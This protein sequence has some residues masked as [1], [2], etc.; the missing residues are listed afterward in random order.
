V[1]NNLTDNSLSSS[2]FVSRAWFFRI[3]MAVCFVAALGIRLYD[4]TDLPLDF[5]P[6]RQLQS[7]IKAR[8][9]F[10]EQAAGVPEWQ[11]QTAVRQWKAMPTEEPEIVE[12]LAVWA[13]QLTGGEYIWLPR[14]FSILFWLAG[15]VGLLFLARSLVGVDGSVIATCFYLFLPYGVYASRAFM[16]DPLMLMF[17]IWGVWATNRWFNQPSWKNAILAGI[18]CGLAIL[19][20]LTA[21]FMIA[22]AAAGLLFGNRKLKQVLGDLQVWVFGALS[23]LPAVIYNLLGIYILG[24]ISQGSVAQRILLNLLIDPLSYLRWDNKIEEVLGISAL[25]LA[26]AGTFLLA[27]RASRSLVI[28]LWA[29]YVLF[30]VF[31]MYYFGTHNYY[32]LPLIP[33]VA[34]GIAP[35]GQLIIQH[36]RVTWPGWPSNAV[37][38]LLLV[39]AI[40]QNLWVERATLRRTDYRPE[41]AFWQGLGYKLRG[42][43]VL[44]LTQDY[45]GRLAY[46]GWFDAVYFPTLGDF[47]HQEITGHAVD[48]LKYFNE[49]SANKDFFLVTLLDELDAQPELKA[50]L[51]EKYPIYS[52]D[53]GYII[54]DLRNPK[55]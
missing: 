52:Q 9:M 25:L 45:N 22:G 33:L 47:Q 10:F 14:L 35:L 19:V 37:I 12:R 1:E 6:T 48:V 7:M 53:T 31:F 55:K 50:A 38:V 30:G 49:V 29:G 16:P 39:L 17:I 42:S 44:A 32:H 5:H 46:W 34:L 28:G 54:F 21:I 20:K 15:G 36:M 51:M 13:Y 8:G 27:K 26:L 41:A 40:F 43:S 23:L 3:F 4:L 11:R 2:I 18:L 24:F